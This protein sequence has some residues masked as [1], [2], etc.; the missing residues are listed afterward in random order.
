VLHKLQARTLAEVIHLMARSGLD[1]ASL[2]AART[3]ETGASETAAR[4]ESRS[5]AAG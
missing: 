4:A 2:A 1:I 5:D 3:G